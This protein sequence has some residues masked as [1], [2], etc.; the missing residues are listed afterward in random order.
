M[1]IV[2]VLY[3]VV[4]DGMCVIVFLIVQVD[5]DEVIVICVYFLKCDWYG[6]FGMEVDKYCM[7]FVGFG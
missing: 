4:V 2:Y 7:W 3:E 5:D 1:L 6:G